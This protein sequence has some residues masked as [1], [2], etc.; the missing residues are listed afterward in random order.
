MK[1]R[2]LGGQEKGSGADLSRGG[3]TSLPKV[4]KS[5]FKEIKVLQRVPVVCI[6]F[7]IAA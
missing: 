2:E 4:E 1:E 3:N 7:L 5:I 6:S